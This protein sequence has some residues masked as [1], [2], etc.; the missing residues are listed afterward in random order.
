MYAMIKETLRDM[1]APDIGGVRAPLTQIQEEDLPLV[2]ETAEKI[3]ELVEK[4]R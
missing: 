4:Y 1:G 2:K 3:Q